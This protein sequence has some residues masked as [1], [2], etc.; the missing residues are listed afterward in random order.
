M[1]SKWKDIVRR[2]SPQDETD[3]MRVIKEGGNLI[4]K[5]GCDKYFRN[6]LKYVRK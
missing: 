4:T 2:A 5:Q 6:M 3:L 1:F